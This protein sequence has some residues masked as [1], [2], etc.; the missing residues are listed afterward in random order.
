MLK[1]CAMC[2]GEV[3]QRKIEKMIKVGSDV[4]LVKEIPAEVCTAC[5]EAYF[6]PEVVK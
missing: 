5:S 1:K 4:V 3:I 2:G 6:T